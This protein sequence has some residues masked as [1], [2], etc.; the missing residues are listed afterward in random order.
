MKPLRPGLRQVPQAAG[1][2]ARRAPVGLLAPGWP[3]LGL[4][5]QAE[6]VVAAEGRAKEGVAAARRPHGPGAARAVQGDGVEVGAAVELLREE[7]LPVVV[8]D[9]D[10]DL[11]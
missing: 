4:A 7:D 5:A 3:L 8:G 1:R 10:V 6:R 2:P 11:A 9:A